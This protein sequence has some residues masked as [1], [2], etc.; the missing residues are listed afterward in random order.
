[1][2]GDDRLISFCFSINITIM[3]EPQAPNPSKH[4][5]MISDELLKKYKDY[6]IFIGKVVSNPKKRRKSTHGNKQ[7]T[8]YKSSC[9]DDIPYNNI[10]LIAKSFHNIKIEFLI[11]FDEYIS[12]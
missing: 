9:C 1:M 2:I 6:N 11:F 12:H 8:Y 3:S 4:Q 10:I 5:R 7:I